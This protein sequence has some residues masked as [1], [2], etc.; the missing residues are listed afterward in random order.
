VWNFVIIG[1]VAVFTP[2]DLA[3]AAFERALESKKMVI[4]KGGQ[5]WRRRQCFWASVQILGEATS[6]GC[7]LHSYT[8]TNNHF[9][10]SYK[11]KEY[12]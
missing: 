11:T 2:T 4:I 10:Y 3:A 9:Q 7:F 8:K 5:P 12:A 1:V 6:V